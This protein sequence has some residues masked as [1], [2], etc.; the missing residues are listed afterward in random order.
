MK[1]TRIASLLFALTPACALARDIPSINKTFISFRDQ[2]HNAATLAGYSDV[3]SMKSEDRLDG[4]LLATGFFTASMRGNE[5]GEAYGAAGLNDFLIGPGHVEPPLNTYVPDT[6]NSKFIARSP[7]TDFLPPDNTSQVELLLTPEQKIGGAKFSYYQ[8]LEG[9]EEGLYFAVHVPVLFVR[10]NIKPTFSREVIDPIVNMSL[11][12]F[13]AGEASSKTPGNL[14]NPL[15]KSKIVQGG[16]SKG[17]VADVQI[18]LGYNFLYDTAHHLGVDF[19]LFIPTGSSTTGDFAFEPVLGSRHYWLGLGL[20]A[21]IV[22]WHKKNHALHGYFDCSYHFILKNDEQRSIGVKGIPFGHYY[23]AGKYEGRD[24]VADIPFFPA[25]NVLTQAVN[26][27]TTGV[28]E[29]IIGLSYRHRHF[30]FDIG[31]DLYFKESER[32]SL[33]DEWVDDVYFIPQSDVLSNAAIT[34]S[35]DPL[36]ELKLNKENLDI[37]AATS[38]AQFTNKIFFAFTYTSRESDYPL[39]FGLGASYEYADNKRTALD[40]YSIFAKAGVS[41]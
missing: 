10:N 35:S 17:G 5:L 2:H 18:V 34:P 11:E 26:V 21:D 3:R 7:T 20:N 13:F 28:F 41:F 27:H 16:H 4:S 14:M 15:T 29:G 24:G 38:R 9:I 30:K 22:M 39:T 1:Q 6:V 40:G 25:T 33:K 8:H 23:Q 36:I 32:V 12:D 31:Y 19:S 37:D